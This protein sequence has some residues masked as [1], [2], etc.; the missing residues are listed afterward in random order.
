MQTSVWSDDGRLDRYN[1]LE[2]YPR[3][4]MVLCPRTRN[5]HI[6]FK[7]KTQTKVHKSTQTKLDLS[8]SV[9]L[10][11]NCGTDHKKRLKRNKFL[12]AKI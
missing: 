8:G 9:G 11:N 4:I 3:K 5:P 7:R 1:G 10:L 6:F 2:P 12:D